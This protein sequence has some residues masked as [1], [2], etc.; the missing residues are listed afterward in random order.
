MISS[1]F[2]RRRRTG[3]ALIC[4]VLTALSR[5]GHAG[6]TPA[7]DQMQF[8]DGLYA[9]GLHDL[10]IREYMALMRDWPAYPKTDL[11][12]YRVAESYRELGNVAAADLFYR[13]VLNEFPDGEFK[14]RAGLRRA[15]LFVT[16][17]QTEDGIRLLEE[18]LAADPPSDLRAGIRYYLGLAT[19]QAGQSDRAA[20]ELSTA[21]K[22]HGDSPYAA[23][24]A[25]ELASIREKAAAP[26][27]DVAAL[28]RRA[29]AAD[30]AS[31]NVVAEA[32]FRLGDYAY[33]ARRYDVSA[34]AY[35]RLLRD[36]PDHAR[37]VEAKLQAAWSML[38]SG[39]YA[40]ALRVADTAA[41]DAPDRDEWLYLMGNGRRQLLDVDGALM[42]YDELLERHPSS[43]LAEGAVYEAALIQ[44]KHRRYEDVARRLSS[45]Q[46]S[47][48]L[49]PDINWLLAESYAGSGQTNLAV[50]HYRLVAEMSDADD[51]AP[52][53]MIRLG[54][55]LYD[56]GDRPEASNVLRGMAARHPKHEGVPA[57][58][59]L[60]GFA[61]AADNHFD[62]AVADWGRIEREFADS[63]LAE[64]ALFQKGLGEIRLKREPQALDTLR[65]LLKR[66]PATRFEPEARFWLGV[67]LDSTGEPASAEEELRRADALDAP[68][69]IRR[70][71]RFRLAGVLHKL[72][73]E[74]A[75]AEL[76]QALIDSPIKEEM[77]PALLEWLAELRLGQS[78][79][80]DAATAA[81]TLIDRS[82]EASWRQIGGWVLGRA[83]SGMK[84]ADGSLA[85]YEMGASGEGATPARLESVLELGRIHLDAGRLDASEARF[86]EAMELAADPSHDARKARA[87]LGLGRVAGTRGDWDAASRYHLGVAILYDLPGVSDEAL[88]LAAHALDQLGQQD[89]RDQILAEL[90]G[91]YPDSPWVRPAPPLAPTS[92]E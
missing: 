82:D 32:W 91:R 11:V 2:L 16:A 5:F 23:L 3:M 15:E 67:V 44:F 52:D 88:H 92:P 89:K 65:G 58:L 38:H 47:D 63:P 26:F 64:E 66:F 14:H 42:A 55:L 37:S 13:R 4:L 74:D 39:R 81:R 75:A 56:R 71:I 72:G 27:D 17:G 20:T 68:P 86:A 21:I 8:A 22:D 51:R 24:A 84:D 73:K 79:F 87:M 35:G 90:L 60:S 77:T 78:R 30:S 7:D 53:A 57:A 45:I 50:Q 6:G 43:R 36:Q 83:L 28:F 29:A 48:S 10:A 85:A 70:K 69:E 54:R 61:L 34:E 19:A 80:E 31:S 76:L 12:L 41:P 33:A 40:D 62:E 1:R 18:C 49:R 25:L 59:L 9:R 46:P